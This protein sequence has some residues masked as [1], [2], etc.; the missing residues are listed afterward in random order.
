[1]GIIVSMVVAIKFCMAFR[2]MQ[3]WTVVV[4]VTSSTEL[5][6]ATYGD[7]F[8]VKHRLKKNITIPEGTMNLI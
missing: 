2:L 7:S 1:M 5:T 4:L 3:Q 8:S 6:V